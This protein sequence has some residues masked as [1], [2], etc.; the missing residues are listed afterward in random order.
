MTPSEGAEKRSAIVR[1]RELM[2]DSAP[3]VD[4]DRPRS[5]MSTIDDGRIAPA[6]A[7]GSTIRPGK[8]FAPSGRT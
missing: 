5:L 3:G 2:T 8:L 7:Y 4:E 6:V 1:D